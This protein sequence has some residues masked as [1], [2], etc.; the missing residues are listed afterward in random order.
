MDGHRLTCGYCKA[1][2][3]G[4]MTA[5]PGRDNSQTD[6]LISNEMHGILTFSHSQII[7]KYAIVEKE[8]LER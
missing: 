2:A 3:N 7:R 8:L 6:A 1:R 4:L 5:F